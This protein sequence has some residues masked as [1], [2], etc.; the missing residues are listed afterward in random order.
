[1]VQVPLVFAFVFAQNVCFTESTKRLCMRKKKKKKVGK[2]SEASF[3]KRRRASVR[4]SAAADAETPPWMK[5]LSS[6]LWSK[7]HDAEVKFNRAKWDQK[8]LEA[9]GKGTYIPETAAKKRKMTA[10][11]K[12]E[13]AKE[14]KRRLEWEKDKNKR[15]LA[16]FCIWKHCKND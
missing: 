12:S 6:Q 9:F 15:I 3:L 13:A 5:K 4:E 10:D 14:K 16:N 1:M 8:A 7:K 2:S 11:L